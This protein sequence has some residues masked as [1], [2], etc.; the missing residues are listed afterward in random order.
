MMKGVILSVLL[1]LTISLRAQEEG[2]DTSTYKSD[3]SFYSY[4]PPIRLNEWAAGIGGAVQCLQVPPAIMYHWMY[5]G[6]RLQ[7]EYE[8]PLEIVDICW[9]NYA[10]EWIASGLCVYYYGRL[11]KDNGSLFGA[12]TGAALAEVA[13]V[14]LYFGT[15]KLLPESNLAANTA[16][17]SGPFI[18][19]T[20]AFT[21]YHLFP[22]RKKNESEAS[23]SLLIQPYLDHHNAGLQLSVKF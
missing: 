15:R 6:F 23:S 22:T 14:G 19:G 8:G 13:W 1:F 11:K 21:G 16:Y 20:G 18:I 7:G 4:N 10:I 3:S 2:V 12:L 9:P 17:L 5:F